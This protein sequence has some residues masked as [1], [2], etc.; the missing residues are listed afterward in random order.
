MNIPRMLSQKKK[1]KSIS[2]K[3][4]G[5]RQLDKILLKIINFTSSNVIRNE[6]CVGDEEMGSDNTTETIT[7]KEVQQQSNHP[8][9]I[10]CGITMNRWNPCF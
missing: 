10:N 9:R 6:E 4:T 7:S 8:S 2:F 1:K 5:A 3:N